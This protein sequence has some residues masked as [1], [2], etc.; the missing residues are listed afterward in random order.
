[1]REVIKTVGLTKMYNGFPAL[2]ELTLTIGP[3]VCVGFIGPN[4]AGKTTTI[5]IL[6]S[7]IRS[8]AGK[9]YVEGF[10]IR[11][12]PK[13][14]LMNVGS[15]VETPEFYPYLTPIETLDYLGRLRGMGEEYV[16]DRSKRVLEQV[17]M[18]EWATT[19]IGKFS[20]GMKQRL[21]IAQALL[22]E[23]TVLILDEPTSGLDPRGMIEVREIIKDLK[24]EKRT[25][26]MSSHLLYEAQE[27]CDWVAMVDKGRLIF[28][29][30]VENIS[31]LT[32]AKKLEIRLVEPITEE[33][34]DTIKNFEGVAEVSLV[35]PEIV[36]LRFGG[37]DQDRA[38]MLAE[39]IAKGA[40]VVSFQSVGME[41]E[42]LYMDMIGSS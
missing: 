8:T 6:T 19:R 26:F 20:K 3:D 7:L 38:K 24:K 2:D 4:G 9:A 37:N 32:G 34:L 35:H 18:E 42:D 28:F 27:V 21:G 11:E 16:R 1:M 15:V 36:N 13:A 25:I 40:M 33:Q 22:H 23:P 14:A 17:H 31:K 39:M 5:K 29:D 30:K 12:S 10:D 41:L